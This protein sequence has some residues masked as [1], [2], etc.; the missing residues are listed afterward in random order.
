MVET[1]VQKIRAMDNTNV[2]L[3]EVLQGEKRMAENFPELTK[4]TS[5]CIKGQQNPK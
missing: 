5:P 3:M 2:G 1:T 4:D